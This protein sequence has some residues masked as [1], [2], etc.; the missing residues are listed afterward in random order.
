M[1]SENTIHPIFG[2]DFARMLAGGAALIERELAALNS[3]NVFPVPDADTGTNMLHTVRRASKEIDGLLGSTRPPVGQVAQLFAEGAFA[4]ARGNS[5]VILSQILSG[6]A[7][8][9]N[10][11]VSLDALGLV[12]ALRKAAEVAY[13]SVSEPVEGTMLTVIRDVADAV[14]SFAERRNVTVSEVL[15]EATR[16][17]H[18]SV[19]RTPELLPVL[20]EHG[21]VDSGALGVAFFLQGMRDSLGGLGQAAVVVAGDAYWLRPVESGDQKEIA[22][23]AEAAGAPAEKAKNALGV[24]HKMFGYCTGFLISGPTAPLNEVRTAFSALGNS[25]VVAQAGESIRVHV[26]TAD[27]GEALAAGLSLGALHDISIRNMDDQYN[28]YVLHLPEHGHKRA[29]ARLQES[30]VLAFAPGEGF[31]V[32]FESLGARVCDVSGIKDE[33]LSSTIHAA[34]SDVPARSII[35]VPGVTRVA[36]ILSSAKVPERALHLVGADDPSSA[37]AA[38]LA[39]TYGATPEQNRQR[40]SSAAAQVTSICVPDEKTPIAEALE[41]AVSDL[42]S[43]E[44]ATLYYGKDVDPGAANKVARAVSD[45]LGVGSCEV[46]YGGQRDCPYLVAIE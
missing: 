27:P 35:V 31:A 16:A 11:A 25:L 4:G 29:E 10:G 1:V 7:A 30:A 46:I 13:S 45:A 20:R 28:E 15:E 21:V 14:A 18:E 36:A 6:F 42:P 41:E 39:F 37:M 19:R 2:V 33:E 8:P 3:L 23:V 34:I 5:G 24:N 17:A 44:I 43:S 12:S 22:P 38:L 40:M 26:H 32:V 9:I